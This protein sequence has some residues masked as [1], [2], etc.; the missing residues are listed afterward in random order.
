LEILGLASGESGQFARHTDDSM[1]KLGIFALFHTLAAFQQLQPSSSIMSQP[2]SILILLLGT[3]VEPKLKKHTKIYGYQLG[4]KVTKTGECGPGHRRGV[5]TF[6]C[7]L[8][9]QENQ[10]I[11][12]TFFLVLSI[13]VNYEYEL[14]PSKRYTSNHFESPPP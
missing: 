9:K 10:F 1:W 11:N 3:Q 12:V 8:A 5:Q 14:S 2:A 7:S 13:T 6:S 4:F